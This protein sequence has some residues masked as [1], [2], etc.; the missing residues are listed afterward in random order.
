MT[1][2]RVSAYGGHMRWLGQYTDAV[3]PVLTLRAQVESRVLGAWGW[4]IE[5]YH[6]QEIQGLPLSMTSFV[7]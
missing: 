6:A 1:R 2:T 3:L 7:Y 4:M 5:G